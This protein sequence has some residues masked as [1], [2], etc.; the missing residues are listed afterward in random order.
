MQ[1]TTLTFCLLPQNHVMP[2]VSHCFKLF[3]ICV[4]C[5][6]V[7]HMFSVTKFTD[8]RYYIETGVSFA[9]YIFNL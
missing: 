5:T 6:A 8:M 4:H 9:F 1:I 3:N 2:H 7:S